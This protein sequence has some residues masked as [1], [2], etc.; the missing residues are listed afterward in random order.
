MLQNNNTHEAVSSLLS[1][2]P[3]ALC[4]LLASCVSGVIVC[5]FL[6]AS[7]QTQQNFV[8]LITYSSLDYK[9]NFEV[10]SLSLYIEKALL[11]IEESKFLFLGKIKAHINLVACNNDI[12]AN[13]FC[14]E[15]VVPV[16]T[17][18]IRIYSCL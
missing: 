11:L 12:L 3:E 18:G 10:L 9:Q 13:I 2:L 5:I 16:Y 17:M 4:T 8:K 7:M 6:C 15:G 1:S 14:V